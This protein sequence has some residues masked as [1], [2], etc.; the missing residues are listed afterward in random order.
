MTILFERAVIAGVGL[1]GGSLALAGKKAGVFGKVVAL[2]RNPE[3]IEKAIKLGIAD[4]GGASPEAVVK[5]A[6]LFFAATPVETIIPLCLSVG[7]KLKPGCVVTDGGSVKG[8]IVSELEAGLPR[9]VPFI[10]GHPV[11]GTEKS[12]PEAA[13]PSLYENRYT[14]LT[15]TDNTDAA[16][17]DKVKMMWERVGAKI[18]IM[19]PEEHDKI[20]AVISHLPHLAAYALVEALD[21]FDSTGDARRFIAGGFKDTTRIAASDPKMWRDIFSMNKD[22]VLKSLD[23]FQA[24]V[25]SLKEDI[26]KERF[27]ALEERLVK[28]KKLRL[29][30]E[31]S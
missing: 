25:E 23:L 1:I 21:E 10:G 8:K 9:D 19:S 4:E 7:P 20:L 31:N 11:A 28:I 3:T 29:D 12:G 24:S 27:D 16:A 15:P 26:K 22:E 6:D 2:S 17:L 13:F 18:V 14:V 30:M 5:D